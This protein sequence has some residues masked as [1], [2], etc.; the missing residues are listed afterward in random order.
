MYYNIGMNNIKSAIILISAS[1]RNIFLE[2]LLTTLDYSSVAQ[3]C[4]V[5]WDKADNISIKFSFLFCGYPHSNCV[6]WYIHGLPWFSQM[7]MAYAIINVVKEAMLIQNINTIWTADK[8]SIQLINYWR[9]HCIKEEQITH[10][11][12]NTIKNLKHARFTPLEKFT[13]E[14]SS[15]C[16]ISSTRSIMHQ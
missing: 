3:M 6:L 13:E 10:V 15:F 8:F 1:F 5:V 16:K 12:E 9:K 11:F 7:A 14:S 2:H 4:S